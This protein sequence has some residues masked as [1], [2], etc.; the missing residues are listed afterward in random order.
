MRS[1][2]GKLQTHSHRK[3]QSSVESLLH[4]ISQ[5]AKIKRKKMK[6]IVECF[7][8]KNISSSSYIPHMLPCFTFSSLLIKGMTFAFIYYSS[9]V[10][11]KILFQQLASIR[12]PTEIVTKTNQRD[13]S[14]FHRDEQQTLCQCQIKFNLLQNSSLHL[15]GLGCQFR[16]LRSRKLTWWVNDDRINLN[17]TQ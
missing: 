4:A 6:W 10:E 8:C 16:C 2:S 14:N 9:A 17:Q 12:K 15:P 7:P 3:F 13:N 1:W 11:M 5:F